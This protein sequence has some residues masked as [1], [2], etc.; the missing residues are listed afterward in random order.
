MAAQLA[1]GE[2]SWISHRS[3]A[4]LHDLT[5]YLPGPIELTTVRDRRELPG[6]TIFRASKAPYFQCVRLGSLVVGDVNMT[7]LNLAAVDSS[8][9]VEEAFDDAL[10]RKLTTAAKLEWFLSRSGGRGNP[11]SGILKEL[12]GFRGRS[13]E[14]PQSVMET[15]MDRL[16]RR[17]RLPRPARQLSVMDKLGTEV[18]RLDFAYPDQRLGIECH[19]YRWH[20]GRRKW[21][22]DLY[23]GN[24]L[25]KLG[26][27]V[28]YFT[29]AQIRDE[30]G[31]VIDQIRSELAVG[32]NF[33][34]K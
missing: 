30:P 1:C 7:L 18:G 19:G 14:V 23:R 8:A 20:S 9:R 29:W 2:G 13:D 17:S 32:L 25:T 4:A 10:A 26:W 22:H 3:G 34:E 28:L 33:G 31:R 24:E 12:I 6:A 27:R 15:R 5:G 16:I 11:G 21:H